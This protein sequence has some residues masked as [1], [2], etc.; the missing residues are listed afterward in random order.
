MVGP[1]RCADVVTS[2]ELVLLWPR[3][4]LRRQ[5]RCCPD[6]L[7][8]EFHGPSAGSL[9]AIPCLQTYA[10]QHRHLAGASVS[11]LRCAAVPLR[12]V[13]ALPPSRGEEGL[14]EAPATHGA[15]LACDR[16]A[17]SLRM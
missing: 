12:P 16:Q 7:K 5:R 6:R 15:D 2:A 8:M 10:L 14:A 1:L 9:L 13:C 4:Q 3:S 17:S 11:H